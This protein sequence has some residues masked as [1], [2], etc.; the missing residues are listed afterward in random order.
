MRP[1]NSLV[2]ATKK[3][4]EGDFDIQVET[5]GSR[6]INRLAESFNDMAVYLGKQSKR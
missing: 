6:E 2:N 5:K 1:L 4:A 3:I